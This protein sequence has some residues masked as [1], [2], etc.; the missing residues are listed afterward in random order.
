MYDYISELDSKMINRISDKIYTLIG[1]KGIDKKDIDELQ[2]AIAFSTN[3]YDICSALETLHY[4]YS[5]MLTDI[6]HRKRLALSGIFSQKP[7]L[8]E[9]KSVLEKKLDAEP[10]Y[11]KYKEIEEY[12]FQFL[13]HIVELKNLIVWQYKEDEV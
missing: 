7:K 4:Y 11:A 1:N 13:E 8:M 3:K 12:L 2:K 10:E 6:R 9:E 5:V